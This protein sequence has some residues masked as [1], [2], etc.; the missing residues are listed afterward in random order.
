MSI[1][2]LY[3][4]ASINMCLYQCNIEVPLLEPGFNYIVVPI[5]SGGKFMQ[6][7]RIKLP[8]GTTNDLFVEVAGEHGK[9]GR[10]G[11]DVCAYI[12]I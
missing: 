12:Y 5:T 4:I 9:D 7:D 3:I 1:V 10:G 6:Q 8:E 11:I 2:N